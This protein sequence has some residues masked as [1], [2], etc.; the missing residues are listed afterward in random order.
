MVVIGAST[1]GPQALTRLLKAMPA[2]LPVPL[3]VIVHLPPGYTETFAA[4]VNEECA[5]DV[6]EASEGVLLR[7]GLAIVGRSGMHL[8]LQRTGAQVAAH[9][10]L[11]PA[12]TPH[13]PSVDVLFESA[14][15][16]YGHAVLGVVLTGM[17]DDGAR[18][19]KAIDAAGGQVLT[20][21]EESCVVYGMPRCVVEA[22]ISS[23]QAP[24]GEMA[25]EIL[26]ML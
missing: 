24:I 12:A 5:I 19:A 18:G 3:A 7:P 6:Q 2:E 9:L 21:S 16:V 23:G 17:G 10:D 22:G 14:A 4:R 11:L 15:E 25:A 1:G 8:K 20:E 13:R 26:K